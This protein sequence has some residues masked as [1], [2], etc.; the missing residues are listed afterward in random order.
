MSPSYDPSTGL[1]FVTA[2]ETCMV[3]SSRKEEYKVGER[4]MGGMVRISGA[5]TGA[6]RA[7][8]AVTGE[9]K[10]EFP[11]PTPSWAGILTTAGGVLFTGDNEGN[12]LAFESRSG[13]SVYRYQIGASV[14]AAP[15]TYMLE[16]RQYVALPA[17]TT[18]TV[19][20]LA[21]GTPTTRN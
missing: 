1:F 15:M 21:S 7:I 3:F 12:F 20:A 8:D 4:W 2:R 13:K 10:W 14:Y 11:Y 17:G 19:F 5:R 16:G 9:R 6:L 18:L